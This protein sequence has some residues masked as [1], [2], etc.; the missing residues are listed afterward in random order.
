MATLERIRS[1]GPILVIIVGLALFAFI[2]GDFLTQGRTFFRNAKNVVA[3]ID[4]EKYKPEDF[5]ALITQFTNARRFE[6]GSQEVSEEEQIQIRNQA[7]QFL[8]QN[9]I[10]NEVT[11]KI[12]MTVSPDELSDYLFGNNIHRIIKQSPLFY[13]AQGQFSP[14]AIKNFLDYLQQ[15]VQ[16]A[17]QR[18]QHDKL[19]SYWNY[20]INNV[21]LEVLRDKYF[22]LIGKSVVTN[23]LEAKQFYDANRTTSD[24]NYLQ[25]PY[26]SVADSLVNIPEADIKNFY[27]KHKHWYKTDEYCNLS[28]VSFELKPSQDDYKSAEDI[29]NKNEQEFKTSDD[30]SEIVNLNSEIPYNDQSVYSQATVPAYLKDFAFSGKKGDVTGP[31]FHD[32]TYTMARITET[33]ISSPDSVHLRHIYITGDDSQKK[34][35]SL[36]NVINAG[37]DFAALAKQ[38]SDIQQTATKGGEIGWITRDQYGGVLTKEIILDAF[39]AKTGDVTSYKMDQGTQIIQVYEKSPARNKVRLAIF[40]RKAVPSSETET[41]I[42][43]QA[44]Q[45]LVNS[46]NN[47]EDFENAAKAKNYIV[48][49]ANNVMKTAYEIGSVQDARKLIQTAFDTKKGKV[50][51]DVFTCKNQFVIAAVTDVNNTGFQTFADVSPSIKAKL[52]QDK[53]GEMI[54]AQI[55]EKMKLNSD[56]N[57]LAAVLGVDVKQATGVNFSSATLGAGGAQEPAVIGKIST[58]KPNQIST[59]VAGNSGVYVVQVTNQNDSVPEYNR[60]QTI[61]GMEMQKN[62][63]FPYMIWQSMIRN[64]NIYDNR[65]TFY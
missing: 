26:F 12:G 54:A 44:R 22:A 47:I 17:E 48:R 41:D 19:Q 56:F 10:I 28:Y 1:W 55:S 21:R 14:V 11:Q 23:N 63:Y 58:L 42:F 43:N 2:V 57:S 15:P 35:D 30:V 29:I 24:V 40:E 45:L 20:L 59:P 9:T 46:K 8:L 3:T 36:V 51:P 5:S 53:K 33:G 65:L 38:F 16:S 25:Q 32:D 61:A 52:I 31:F 60:A 39:K 6:R 7:W 4:G 50:L 34:A 27:E 18:D 62:Y 13:D 49:T 64:A 37:G